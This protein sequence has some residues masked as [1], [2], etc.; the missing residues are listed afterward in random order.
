MQSRRI[1]H[2]PVRPSY[3]DGADDEKK[4]AKVSRREIIDGLPLFH[5]IHGALGSFM[6]RSYRLPFITRQSSHSRSPSSSSVSTNPE[7]S[8]FHRFKGQSSLTRKIVVVVLLVTG[9]WIIIVLVPT[10]FSRFPSDQSF[11]V[12]DYKSTPAAGGFHSRVTGGAGRHVGRRPDDRYGG[13]RRESR[14]PIRGQKQNQDVEFQSTEEEL[15]ALLYVSTAPSPFT[16]TLPLGSSRTLSN[17]S[18][19]LLPLPTN[20]SI[21]IRPCPYPLPPYSTSPHPEKL[22]PTNW[23]LSKSTSKQSIPSFSSLALP[24]TFQP[25]NEI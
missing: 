21:L 12:V 16:S 24:P 9:I 25:S 23:T 14:H 19:S 6:Q 5:T 2:E 17:P 13:T 20:L 7:S 18:F 1:V 4:N 11:G 10:L 3:Q 8:S 15:I 22:S